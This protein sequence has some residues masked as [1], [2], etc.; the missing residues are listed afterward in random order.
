MAGINEL[1]KFVFKFKSLLEAGSDANLIVNAERGVAKISLHVNVY[2][3]PDVKGS[4]SASISRRKG[5]AGSPSRQR[6]RIRREAE[7]LAR[8][9]AAV[10]VGGNEAPRNVSLEQEEV[11]EVEYE[12]IV[13][14]KEDVT[15]YEITEAIEENFWGALKDQTANQE[16]TRDSIYVY[17]SKGAAL[18]NEETGTISYIYKIFVNNDTSAVKVVEKWRDPG[19]FDDL[20]FGN[21]IRD[22]KQVRI[23]KIKKI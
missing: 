21:A 8:T 16:N 5:G 2:Y 6:R 13:D 11:S 12:L 10:A 7:R 22:N 1:D 9:A 18:K 20:A 4:E 23:R 17:K 19:F 15:N 3:G 14:T